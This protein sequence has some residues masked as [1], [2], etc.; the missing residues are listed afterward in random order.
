[1]ELAEI[2]LYSGYNGLYICSSLEQSYR[3]YLHS[4]NELCVCVSVCVSHALCVGDR[5]GAHGDSPE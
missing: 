4:G 2:I 3:F 1:M 5:R